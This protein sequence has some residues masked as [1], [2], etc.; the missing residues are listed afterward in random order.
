MKENRNND[1]R[2]TR[3]PKQALM[4]QIQDNDGANLRQFESL[5]LSSFEFLSDFEFSGG[6]FNAAR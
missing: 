4:K 3:N 1:R 5:P 6:L 2:K